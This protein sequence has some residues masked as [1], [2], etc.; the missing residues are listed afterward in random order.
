MY[1]L[2]V[3]SNKDTTAKK[4]R[5]EQLE[6]QLASKGY[7][8]DNILN[9]GKQLSAN[10]ALAILQT[11]IVHIYLNVQQLQLEISRLAGGIDKVILN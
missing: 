2:I 9:D 1:Q 6:T 10:N 3:S 8:K 7:N 5:L 11:R 4:R